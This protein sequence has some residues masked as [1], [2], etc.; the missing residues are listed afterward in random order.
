MDKLSK[1]IVL[2]LTKE[3]MKELEK[4]VTKH[5]K[6]TDKMVSAQR[7]YTDASRACYKNKS[8]CKEDKKLQKLAD[9][10]FKLEYETIMAKEEINKYIII[11]TKKY[12]K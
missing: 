5:K 2:Q 7:A 4:L 11:L 3:E 12:K 6:L 10:G 1:R 9:K 8:G